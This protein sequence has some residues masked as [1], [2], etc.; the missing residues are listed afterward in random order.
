[1]PLALFGAVLGTF[2]RAYDNNIYTQIGIVLLIGLA[3]KTAILLVEFAKQHHEEGHTIE[4][5][6]LAA[7]RLRFRPILMT[8]LTFVLGVVPLVVATGAGAA[9]RKALGTTVFSGMLTA[10]FFGVLMIPVFYVVI[11]K[12]ADKL[13]FKRKG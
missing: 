9:S 3:S 5:A 4:D 1:V 13:R 12:L 11:Q 8:A 6:A 2:I 7:A 10:T